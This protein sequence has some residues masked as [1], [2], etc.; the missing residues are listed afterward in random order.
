MGSGR[1]AA[2]GSGRAQW[3][4]AEEQ[5]VAVEEDLSGSGIGAAS[6]SDRGSHKG[7]SVRVGS[8]L[9]QLVSLRVW[10]CGADQLCDGESV[11]GSG[12]EWHPAVVSKMGVVTGCGSDSNGTSS[13]LSNM[14]S[15]CDFVLPQH[16]QRQ[17]HAH[18]RDTLSATQCHAQQHT[19]CN[20]TTDNKM[21]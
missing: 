20:I 1:R 9:Y 18:H 6:G 17:W 8:V 2:S 13:N 14:I 7:S 19:Q 21:P 3:S 15:A 11:S 10:L 5:P 12:Y 4:V 16:P